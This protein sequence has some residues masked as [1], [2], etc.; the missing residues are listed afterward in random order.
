MSAIYALDFDF[1]DHLPYPENAVLAPLEIPY[2]CEDIEPY[3][4]KGFR[5]FPLRKGWDEPFQGTVRDIA[6][7]QSWLYFGLLSDFFGELLDTKDFVDVKA[8]GEKVV[9]TKK[10]KALLRTTCQESSEVYTWL[11]SHG[12]IDKS[13][14][15]IV[16]GRPRVILNE[17]ISCTLQLAESQSHM[18]DGGNQLACVIALSIKVLIWSIRNA[19]A[20]YLPSRKEKI[21]VMPRN[22]RLLRGAMLS[23]GKCPYWTEIYLRNYSPGMIYYIAAMPSMDGKADHRGCS[24]QTCKAHDTHDDT[25]V[26]EHTHTCFDCDMTGPD[27]EKVRS[28]IEDG[29]IPLI[30]FRD[31]PAGRLALDVVQA[32]YGLHYTAISHVW[33]GGLGNPHA[34]ILPQCQLKSIRKG[35]PRFIR[36]P[37][38][39]EV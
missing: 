32:T 28:I 33:S 11:A 35:K 26:V 16:R 13:K 24:V 38:F 23:G 37:V 4:G 1:M 36:S 2:I 15:G 6:R 10:L 30:R 5:D 22:G 8:G 9:T 7:A 39:C 25:Y 21:H 34:N 27:P 14:R 29:G 3:D 20:T 31:L 19:L 18:L 12:F 17:G